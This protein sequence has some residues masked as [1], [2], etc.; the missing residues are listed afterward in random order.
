LPLRAIDHT[1]TRWLSEARP[2]MKFQPGPGHRSIAVMP[3]TAASFGCLRF[4]SVSFSR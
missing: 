4:V 2:N 3:S 1:P